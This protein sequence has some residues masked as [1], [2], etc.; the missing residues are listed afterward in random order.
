MHIAII[1]PRWVGD[2]VMSTPM[3]RA[4]RQHFGKGAK[5]T[6]VVKPLFQDILAGTNW[7]DEFIA[8]DRHSKK[9]ESSFRQA[10]SALR[11]DRPDIAL[12]IPNSL[13]SAALAWWGGCRRR[14]GYARHGRRLLLTDPLFPVRHGG[15]VEVLSTAQHSMDL[16]EKIGVPRQPL[17]LELATLPKD[18]E[19]MDSLMSKFFEGW[20]QS[21]SQPLFVF[22]D[23]AAYGPAKSWG[24]ERFVS[25]ARQLLQSY[26]DGRIVVHC[27]PGERDDARS[28]EL[29]LNDSRVRSL[30]DVDKLPFGLSKALLRRASIVITTDSGPRHIAAAFRTPTVVLHGPMDPRL[31]MSDHKNLIELR[32]ELPC[33]P[34]GQRIC[35]L[36]HHDCMVGLSVDDVAHATGELLDMVSH[37]GEAH[38]SNLENIE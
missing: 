4:V 9:Q 3:I 16:A 35:P 37:K 6:A 34:C 8:Y 7:F 14:V 1:L 38:P 32:K 17:E 29:S 24:G 5:L 28:L 18:E 20:T 36:E 19:I 31:G 33:S 30:A 23:N 22:N 12:L 26:P 11:S 15:Q 2:L 27:G 13:S 21:N 25:L 10:A